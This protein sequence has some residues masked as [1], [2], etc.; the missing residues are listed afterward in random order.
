[1]TL[2]DNRVVKE[3]NRNFVSG[4]KNIKGKTPY[5]GSSNTHLP[6]YEAKC[7]NNSS[8][9]HNVQMFVLT[10]DGRVVHCLPGFWNA[11]HFLEEVEFA[12]KLGKLYYTKNVSTAK[13]NQAFMD[14]NLDHAI[15]HT[16]SMRSASDLQGF[17]KKKMAK[18]KN[19]DFKREEGFI[20]SGLKTAD[21][22]MHERMAER[23]YVPF[24]RFDIATYIDMGL[25]RYKYDNGVP[26]K[27]KYAKPTL[28]TKSKTSEKRSK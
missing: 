22:V 17:D 5:A 14:W 8:G 3:L 21:Q 25:K 19:G 20:T 16:R 18:K 24:D 23:P 28:P 10:H 4:W 7:V 15:E 27:G 6:T 1:M 2:S 9:H 11:K 13:R 12:K 26:G